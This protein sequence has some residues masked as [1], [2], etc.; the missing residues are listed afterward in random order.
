MVEIKE[1]K[2]NRTLSQN[3][4]LHLIISAFGVHFGYSL[5]E[6]KQVYKEINKGIYAYE[7][8]G[9]IFW[10]SSADLNTKEMAQTIDKFLFVSN[11][12][13]CPL[14]LATDKEWLMQIENEAERSSRHL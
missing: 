5:E 1:F 14:P 2:F 3:S 8:K 13:G 12:A 11:E 4:Y 6:A 9:R 10:R 7:K